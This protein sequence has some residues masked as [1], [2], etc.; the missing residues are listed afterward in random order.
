MY[1]DDRYVYLG[2]LAF[3]V[4]ITLLVVSVLLNPGWDYYSLALSDLGGS[5]NYPSAIAF[6]TACIASGFI[7]LLYAVCRYIRGGSTLDQISAVFFIY[8]A[9]FLIGVGVFPVSI[10]FFHDINAILFGLCMG[11]A[12]AFATLAEIM[13]GRI[14]LLYT[15]V[16]MLAAG[17]VIWLTLYG[18][19][20]EMGA[21]ILLFCWSL[22]HMY[23]CRRDNVPDEGSR[24]TGA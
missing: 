15:G 21:I 6:E 12:V 1:V 5:T 24:C 14:L 18:A 3:L 19:P 4:Y 13:R 7:M 23:I 17:A 22:V 2:P 16:A 10:K 11:F 8:G 20:C 9:V